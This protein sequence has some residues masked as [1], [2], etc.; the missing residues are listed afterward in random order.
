MAVK[1]HL[2]HAG[3][4]IGAYRTSGMTQTITAAF[5]YNEWKAVTSAVTENDELTSYPTLKIVRYSY[6]RV[7]DSQSWWFLNDDISSVVSAITKSWKPVSSGSYNITMDCTVGADTIRLYENSVTVYTSSDQYD[8]SGDIHDIPSELL[9]QKTTPTI[10]IVVPSSEPYL[11][12]HKGNY[13]DINVVSP[14]YDRLADLYV[15][16]TKVAT[17]TP[18][19]TSGGTAQYRHYYFDKTQAY[20]LSAVT[21]E[22]TD[23]YSAT[24]AVTRNRYKTYSDSQRRLTNRIDAFGVGTYFPSYGGVTMRFRA[25]SG[26]NMRLRF[27]AWGNWVIDKTISSMESVWLP[28][29]RDIGGSTPMVWVSVDG[30][31]VW[32]AVEMQENIFTSSNDTVSPN[33]H[34]VSAIT[35]SGYIQW[36]YDYAYPDSSSTKG[37]F[38]IYR[39]TN[40]DDVW[41]GAEMIVRQSTMDSG[42]TISTPALPNNT[43]GITMERACDDIYAQEY[44]TYGKYSGSDNPYTPIMSA[45]TDTIVIAQ[46]AGSYRHVGMNVT[47]MSQGTIAVKVHNLYSDKIVPS[48]SGLTATITTD[49]TNKIYTFSGLTVDQS[50]IWDDAIKFTCVTENETHFDKEMYAYIVADAS[51][52]T[53]GLLTAEM[54][55]NIIQ[56]G[57]PIPTPDTPEIDPPSGTYHDYFRVTMRTS[58]G[59]TIRYTLDGT[60]P[61]SASTAYNILERPQI[62][63]NGTTLKAKAF[64]NDNAEITSETATATYY[65]RAEAPTFI[66]TDNVFTED[67]AV[68]IL[69]VQNATVK[70]SVDGGAYY[71]YSMPFVISRTTNI[72]AYSKSEKEGIVDSEVVTKQYR[73][74][75]PPSSMKAPRNHDNLNGIYVKNIAYT[76]LPIEMR[77]AY[78]PPTP[79]LTDDECD[80]TWGYHTDGVDEDYGSLGTKVHV[81][82]TTILIHIDFTHNGIDYSVDKEIPVT[83]LVSNK[84]VKMYTLDIIDAYAVMTLDNK[85]KIKVRSRVRRTTDEEVSMLQD[86]TDYSLTGESDNG[87]FTCTKTEGYFVYD[88]I[89]TDDYLGS[90]NRSN[91]VVLTLRNKTGEIL[92]DYVIQVTF[93]TGSIFDVRDDAIRMAVA[94]S[95]AYTD[96]QISGVT[97]MIGELEVNFSAITATVE[98]HTTDI[99]GLTSDIGQLQVRANEISLAVSAITEDYV[100]HS[101]LAVTA[102]AISASVW[103]EFG[104]RTGLDIEDGIITLHAE[105]TIIDGQLNISDGITFR[106]NRGNPV[107]TVDGEAIDDYYNHDNGIVSYFNAGGQTSPAVQYGYTTGK[108]P[109][110]TYQSGDTISFLL[111]EATSVFVKAGSSTPEYD[112]SPS[113]VTQI[114]L[115]KNNDSEPFETYSPSLTKTSDG[116]YRKEQNPIYEFTVP[117]NNA[118]V[119]V[120]FV[121]TSPKSGGGTGVASGSMWIKY[122]QSKSTHNH[123]GKSGIIV[124]HTVNNTTYIGANQFTLRK[125]TDGFSFMPFTDALGTK[126]YQ[127]AVSSLYSYYSNPSSSWPNTPDRHNTGY[128]YGWTPFSNYTPHTVIGKAVTN[129]ASSSGP[130]VEV[131]AITGYDWGNEVRF[132]RIDERYLVGDLWVDKV[133]DTNYSETDVTLLLP[134]VARQVTYMGRTCTYH[135]PEGYTV[136]ILALRNAYIGNRTI[137][138]A[139]NHMDCPSSYDT[140]AKFFTPN[141]GVNDYVQFNAAD[142][143]IEFIYQGSWG[144]GISEEYWQ[145]WYVRNWNN[146]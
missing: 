144:D 106:D 35:Q 74:T 127:P 9:P 95:S 78:I 5:D 38:S 62:T 64:S 80:V 145:R 75:T 57:I 107:T 126:R 50:G 117:A 29:Y 44:Y 18:N 11:A 52:A 141:G 76:G 98:Q 118:N 94:T 1:R 103:N 31:S 111:I 73:K 54:K 69:P 19:P 48:I 72:T 113:I 93:E 139:A 135:L 112:T 65:L 10:S 37:I 114:Q 46:P 90:E 23:Y 146:Q 58:T 128:V 16:G 24:A 140:T 2:G 60:E 133:F 115:F 32:N 92:D 105:Q 47:Q 81:E 56:E 15:N 100:T 101:E 130:V 82:D 77:S 45:S 120:R 67:L 4:D 136:R 49:D 22:D 66:P 109:I 110:G 55:L 6:Q 97:N 89:L 51:P 14:D 41:H 70:Y 88:G 116:H 25:W 102:S 28:Y 30:D 12:D 34:I 63:Q 132:L 68:S 129:H 21:R 104:E 79:T 124:D 96:G 99:S 108:Y 119:S 123:I 121:N 87:N 40:T 71:D 39:E 61:T 13:F 3:L 59:A 83:C 20:N 85:F 36:N 33:L 134:P 27:G 142:T 53:H 137:R 122:G 125:D 86:L 91:Q 8:P 17:V 26:A 42:K 131:G 138:V 143:Y 7:E 84:Q 43:Y